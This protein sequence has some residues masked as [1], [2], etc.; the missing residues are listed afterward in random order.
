MRIGP[1]QEFDI[2]SL[3]IGRVEANLVRVTG[4]EI[5]TVSSV[6]EEEKGEGAFDKIFVEV[7]SWGLA[8]RTT[9]TVRDGGACADRE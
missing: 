7:E 2:F 9:P 6:L 3:A 5:L 4:Q 1:T 8:G